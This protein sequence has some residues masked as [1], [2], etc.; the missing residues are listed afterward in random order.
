MEIK[1][2]VNDRSGSQNFIP[3]KNILTVP[4]AKGE[5]FTRVEAEILIPPS[6]KMFFNGYQSWTHCPEYKASDL[7]HGLERMPKLLFKILA[8]DHFS[9]YHFVDYPYK[10][11]HFH[12]FSYC[13][14]RDGDHYKLISSLDEH[15]GYTIF[16]Y[17]AESCLLKLERD[18]IGV[19]AKEEE[20]HAF[21]LFYTEGDENEVFDQ[22]FNAMD[23]HNSPPKIK[24]YTSWYNRYQRI[25]EKNILKDLEGAQKICSNG[26]LFQIDDGWE[27]A[28]GDWETIDPKKFPNGLRSV[29]KKIREA[30]LTAGLWL[31]PF[32][33]ERKSVLFRKH[34]DWLLRYKKGYWRNG[35]N[36]GGSYSLDIDHLEVQTFLRE[37]F[38]RVFNDW[39]FDLV[40]L[41]F[42]YA[43][44]PLATGEH[45]DKGEGPY[46]ESRAARMIRAME[47]L[48][49]CCGN[50][51]ILACGVPLMPAFGLVDY[52]RIGS[53][54]G[55]NWDDHPFMR[56]LHR[57]RVSTKQSIDNTVYRRHL[58]GKAFG[59]D[60]D[61]F[62]LRNNN[63]SLSDAEKEYLSFANAFLGSMW[64]TSDNLY[65]YDNQKMEKYLLLSDLRNVTDFNI[66]P[67][68]LSLSYELNKEKHHIR[69]PKK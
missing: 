13:Y 38:D 39:N 29:V 30:G 54:M 46:T 63:V 6:P 23:L 14:F 4:V 15:P 61:V 10:K 52:C 55:L 56:R 51:L 18:C 28:V 31:A 1:W 5:V 11:G 44:A 48:R 60:P 66:D 49:E 41:D 20:F 62:F 34:P 8:L 27:T 36:W 69:Y 12:G 24:G 65:T 35:P 43:A 68:D 64:L 17:D 42:L 50:K 7:I 9:D 57:E 26:D 58:N 32:V 53:D 37:V 47:F 21:D 19:A 33:C 2:R 16:R 40:K 22:W 59:N 25:N 3:G 45:G 67:D